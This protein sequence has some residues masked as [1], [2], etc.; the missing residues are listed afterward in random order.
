MALR[1]M[2]GGGGCRHDHAPAYGAGTVTACVAELTDGA[3][4]L[5]QVAWDRADSGIPTSLD[6]ALRSWQASWDATT[7]K[8]FN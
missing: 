7:L 3:H 6:E 8:L 1:R 2:D 5:S 4:A